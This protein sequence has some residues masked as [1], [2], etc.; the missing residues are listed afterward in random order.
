[1]GETHSE[2]GP[3]GSGEIRWTNP[4]VIGLA[5]NQD[6]VET[7]IRR[8]RETVLQAFDR[9]WSGPPFDPVKLADLLNIPVR[10][11]A[12]VVDAQTVPTSAGRSIIEFN[13]QQSRGRVRFSIAHEI[14]HTFFPDCA[15][16]I[17]HRGG[18]DHSRSDDWQLEMLCNIAAAEITMPIGD[19]TRLASG[20][21]AIERV[22]Q[23]RREF[24]VS[25]EAI[26]IRITKTTDDPI[27]MFS[28][29]R[30]GGEN[31]EGFR[32]DYSIRSRASPQSLPMIGA[33]S[34]LS[35]CTA[36]GYTAH[37]VEHWPQFKG[38]LEVQC[39]GLPPYPGTRYPRIAGI[40][41]PVRETDL[42]GP[43]LEYL[44]GDAL[45]PR[46][47]GVR[48]ICHVVN[49]GALTWGGR[50]FAA[51][52]RRRCPQVQEDFKTWAG[53]SKQGLRLGS[54]HFSV[55]EPGL[56]VASMIAQRGYG[57]S[58]MPRIR[59]GALQQCLEE[60]AGACKPGLSVHMPRIGTG[61]ARGSWP[62]IEAIMLTSC[63][64]LDCQ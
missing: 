28:A 44:H 37:R 8:A 46:G 14:A 42:L 55:I 47:Q 10:P 35:E 2:P 6:P 22:T 7:I 63:L 26:L 16:A 36:I 43:H 13:P 40:I 54:V 41:R 58:A 30:I 62:L 38:D 17:R 11:H 33:T 51:N 45:S 64:Q 18:R 61:A 50:G 48:L 39:V 29:S 57:P 59:Y 21:V 23:L 53:G 34:V 4:S 15:S 9:G 60:V 19:I 5:G 1:M 32:I 49:D 31:P 27:V 25:T 52:L 20:R 12:D 24:D 56:M 3:T